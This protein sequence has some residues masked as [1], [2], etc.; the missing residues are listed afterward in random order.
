[1]NWI[2]CVIQYVFDYLFQNQYFYR[3]CSIDFESTYINS[4]NLL[5][6]RFLDHCS[7]VEKNYTTRRCVVWPQTALIIL[8][9]KNIR[10]K[11][12]FILLYLPILQKNVFVSGKVRSFG[13]TNLISVI[14][15]MWQISS[16]QH[17]LFMQKTTMMSNPIFGFARW[18]N[19]PKKMFW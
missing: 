12:T 6:Q 4:F 7:K 11:V 9:K 2:A 8:K 17:F 15:K 10:M 18:H 1:M 14:P 5:I 13:E 3:K 19:V 16:W